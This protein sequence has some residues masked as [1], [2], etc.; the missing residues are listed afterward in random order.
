M[1]ASERRRPDAAAAEGA[2][3][4][5]CSG[6]GADPAGGGALGREAQLASK[7]AAQATEVAARARR[8]DQWYFIMLPLFRAARVTHSD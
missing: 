3:G 7:A 1:L 4:A 8:Q 6:V 5:A 2:T